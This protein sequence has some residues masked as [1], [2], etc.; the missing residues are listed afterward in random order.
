MNWQLLDLVR[1]QSKLLRFKNNRFFL[2]FLGSDVIKAGISYYE[3]QLQKNIA[4]RELSGQNF[5]TVKGNENFFLRTKSLPIT[6]RKQFFIAK[7]AEC[8]KREQEVDKETNKN[9]EE[10]S[11]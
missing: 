10:S 11:A 1:V 9:V 2:S 6:T 7:L 8:E 3:K 5:Y 4:I